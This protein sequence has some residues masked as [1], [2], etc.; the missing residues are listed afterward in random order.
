MKLG[1]YGISLYVVYT[2]NKVIQISRN[3]VPLV[4]IIMIHDVQFCL[5][6]NKRQDSETMFR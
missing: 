3:R 5:R 6:L 1:A 2:V 4:G